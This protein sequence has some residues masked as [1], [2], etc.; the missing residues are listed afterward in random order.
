VIL[1]PPIWGGFVYSSI[2]ITKGSY[3]KVVQKKVSE[4]MSRLKQT[5]MKNTKNLVFHI[6]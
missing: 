2:T 4:R 5:L 1:P 6:I 3:D